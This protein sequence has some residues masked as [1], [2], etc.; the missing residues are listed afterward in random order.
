MLGSQFGADAQSLDWA[1]PSSIT[2]VL[3][4][5]KIIQSTLSAR[6]GNLLRR[7]LK[8]ERDN[9]ALIIRFAHAGAG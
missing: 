9:D 5:N 3:E 1:E 6:L 4:T 8:D 7:S 2:D